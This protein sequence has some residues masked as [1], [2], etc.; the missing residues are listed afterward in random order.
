MVYDKEFN[1]M[2]EIK[3]N[4]FYPL[5]QIGKYQD[6]LIGYASAEINEPLYL[7]NKQRRSQIDILGV[8]NKDRKKLGIA[9]MWG[10]FDVGNNKI[11]YVFPEQ[12]QI[13]VI[14]GNMNETLLNLAPSYFLTPT[15]KLKSMRDLKGERLSVTNSV[16]VEDDIL[17]LG[18]VKNFLSKN[19]IFLFDIYKA[20]G[21]NKSGI[22]LSDK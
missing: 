4:S 2:N 22:I 15:K 8:K 6:F 7:F 13:F 20:R 17:I 1:F 3:K 11:Y 5:V 18:Y 19:N 21:K 9:M 12:Y 10:N 16:F 14:N